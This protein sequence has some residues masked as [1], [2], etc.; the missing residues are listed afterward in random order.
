MK[1]LGKI[2]L[3]AGLVGLAGV[4]GDQK[5]AQAA[6]PIIE[7]GVGGAQSLPDG[8]DPIANV[9][10]KVNVTG[11]AH[12]PGEN[13]HVYY[14]VGKIRGSVAGDGSDV[15]VYDFE[16]VPLSAGSMEVGPES[17][18]WAGLRLAHVFGE[19]NVALDNGRMIGVNVI[20]IELG[21]QGSLG[22]AVDV[23]VRAAV[24]F[25]GVAVAERISDGLRIESGADSAGIELEA[26][27]LGRFKMVLGHKTRKMLS[28]GHHR[29]FDWMRDAYAAGFDDS[30]C[31]HRTETVETGEY[32]VVTD[33]Q[34]GYVREPI[35]RDENYFSCNK[36][37]QIRTSNRSFLD[38]SARLTRALSVFGGVSYSVYKAST[39]TDA[40]TASR[41]GGWMLTLGGAVQV[42]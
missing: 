37:D 27:V 22:P 11:H 6:D 31:S 14:V 29:E 16:F 40:I 8:Q 34:G 3:T 2:L 38:V 12:L 17:R 28:G 23:A 25:G 26:E 32:V 7:I 21:A 36:W 5:R 19:R 10:L 4:G 15:S 20:G 33:G 39:D 35:Y 1:R 9:F 41:N 24:D 30:Q 18:L 13:Q 42:H